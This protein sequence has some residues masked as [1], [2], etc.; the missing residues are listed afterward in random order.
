[1]HESTEIH[2]A[3]A[4]PCRRPHIR[5]VAQTVAALAGRR[6]LESEDFAEAERLLCRGDRR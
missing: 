4:Y 3:T 6:H 5:A 2:A 1:M